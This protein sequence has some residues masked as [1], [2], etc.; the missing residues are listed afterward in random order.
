MSK[1]TPGDGKL[2][3]DRL[4]AKR[5]DVHVRT[6]ARWE[7]TPGLEFPPPIYILRRRYREIEKL[8]QW[9]RDNVRRIADAHSPHRD[10]AQALPRAG[11]GRFT[12]SRDIEVCWNDLLLRGANPEAQK[13]EVDVKDFEGGQV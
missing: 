9:D 4:V 3:P 12:K 8:D 11:A 7:T 13:L 1:L 5:Y 6:L 10:C 2:L